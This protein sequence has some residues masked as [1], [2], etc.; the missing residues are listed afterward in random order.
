MDY[1]IAFFRRKQ[2]ENAFRI[3]VTDALYAITANTARMFGG[4]SMKMRYADLING[5]PQNAEQE[6]KDAAEVVNHIK[7]RLNK[8]NKG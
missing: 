4:S 6:T 5:T 8:L 2:K 3:Y 7:D 1:C